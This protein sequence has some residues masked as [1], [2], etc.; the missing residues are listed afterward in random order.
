MVQIKPD[1]L[2][3]NY[4][5]TGGHKNGFGS[6]RLGRADNEDQRFPSDQNLKELFSEKNPRGELHIG[7]RGVNHVML[8]L[9]VG[10]SKTVRQK[11]LSAVANYVT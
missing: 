2:I 3:L 11:F 10:V 9:P 1:D 8:F 7:S 6:W 4:F 5:P